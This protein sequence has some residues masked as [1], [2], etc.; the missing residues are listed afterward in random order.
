MSSTDFMKQKHE[1]QGFQPFDADNAKF[2][3]TL[4][5][6]K[7]Y[8][9]IAVR[10]KFDFNFGWGLWNMSRQGPFKAK[11]KEMVNAYWTDRYAIVLTGNT[12][13]TSYT[14]S[15]TVVVVED[16]HNPHFTVDVQRLSFGRSFVTSGQCRLYSDAVDLKPTS[17]AMKAGFHAAFGEWGHDKVIF[18]QAKREFQDFSEG[19]A[20]YFKK[21]SD[22]PSDPKAGES[23]A[24]NAKSIMAKRLPLIPMK[25]RGFHLPGETMGIGKRR[26]DKFIQKVQQA[27]FPPG[28]L[29]AIEGGLA[30]AKIPGAASTPL[31][32]AEIVL[33]IGRAERE[34]LAEANDFPIAAHEFGHMLGL[35]DEYDDE[36]KDY[37]VTG[38]RDMAK[39]Y[40]IQVPPFS[41]NTSSLMSMGDKIL[42]FHYTFAVAAIEKMATN[43]TEYGNGGNKNVALTNNKPVIKVGT[44]LLNKV[45]GL[46]ANNGWL[47]D[48]AKQTGF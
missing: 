28:M 35:P 3:A 2:D 13:S 34:F 14:I 8:M 7:G 25:I 47:R 33:D 4:L 43:F 6:Y 22:E 41:S 27:G 44:S 9:N 16:D 45:T 37:A 11:F 18:A 26:A 32:K 5:P 23:F 31:V 24:R 39:K 20:P 12:D 30:I 40:G 15:P 48:F 19:N 21:D 17:F 10:L 38:C 46:Y 29:V 42:P 36:D 1:L